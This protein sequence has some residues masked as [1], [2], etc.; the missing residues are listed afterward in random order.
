[1]R[2]RRT[3]IMP[4]W[5][6]THFRLFLVQRLTDIK[7]FE[8]VLALNACAKTNIYKRTLFASF[9]PVLQE[10]ANE[11][12]IMEV[13]L[14]CNALAKFSVLDVGLMKA[15]QI[16][17]EENVDSINA[18]HCGLILHAYGRL[19]IRPM[20]FISALEDQITKVLKGVDRQDL[21][22]IINSLSK[23]D[24]KCG[25]ELLITLQNKILE[26]MPETTDQ[27]LVC[28]TYA[29]LHPY[30]FQFNF[31]VQLLMIIHQ[32]KVSS[33][34]F[35]HQIGI[36]MHGLAFF[37]SPLMADTLAPPMI[38]AEPDA[39]YIYK[40]FR[41]ERSMDSG[42]DRQRR[43]RKY[44]SLTQLKALKQVS[45]TAE[46]YKKLVD[47]YDTQDSSFEAEIEKALPRWLTQSA[48]RDKLLGPYKTDI[49]LSMDGAIEPA[50]NVD[51][52]GFDEMVETKR[53]PPK[54]NTTV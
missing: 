53:L 11:L 25:I 17:I 31:M 9:M 35:A 16:V 21:P 2:I 24:Y 7:P 18:M 8:M 20:S 36:A 3:W 45:D 38:P 43:W 32:R 39:K 10:H 12:K 34:A 26:K 47:F 44:L 54:A 51:V 6:F 49:V 28:I 4:L 33:R 29:M 15:L 50:E 52:E 40:N 19:S 23:L 14:L 1:M 5:F 27:G 46:S 41:P 42:K 37:H 30:Y 48:E 13:A 22:H